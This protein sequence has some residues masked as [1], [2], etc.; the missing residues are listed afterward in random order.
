MIDTKKIRFGDH[1]TYCIEDFVDELTLNWKIIYDND[2]NEIIYEDKLIALLSLGN[3]E[4]YNGPYI[5]QFEVLNTYKKMGYGTAIM[6]ELLSEIDECYV[7]PD[8]EMAARF[9]ERLGFNRE[10]DGMGGDV[11][12]YCK[13]R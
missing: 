11:W 5:E 2:T 4:I 1:T 8:S 9:W 13:L 7:L 10:D 3:K 6:Q 12:Y